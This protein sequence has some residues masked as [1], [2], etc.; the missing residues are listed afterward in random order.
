VLYKNKYF[1]IVLMVT[2]LL[3]GCAYRFSGGGDMPYDINKLSIKI[4]ENRSSENGI[5]NTITND[6]VN[7]FSKRGK[8]AVVDASVSD[9]ILTGVV[10]K[11]KIDTVSRQTESVTDEQRVTVTIT[12]KIADQDGGILWTSNNISENEVYTVSSNKLIT[13]QNRKQAIA[14]LSEKLAQKT[15]NNLTEDF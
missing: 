3:A 1:S 6:F 13:E 8:V 12:V 2:L 7:E 11:V 14:V 5:Q 10:E 9:S 15:Y 4:F